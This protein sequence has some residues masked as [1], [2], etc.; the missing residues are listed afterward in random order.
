MIANRSP[1]TPT[2]MG[3]IRLRTAAVATAASMAL[4]PFFRMSNP[5]WAA[6]GWLVVTMPLRAMT[7][8][9]PC[10]SHPSARSPST[11]LHQAGFAVALHDWTGDCAIVS[12]ELA[13]IATN[14]RRETEFI[15]MLRS[16][17]SVTRD[18]DRVYSG[19]PAGD[20]TFVSDERLARP[21]EELK[22]RLCHGTTRNA[23]SVRS[24]PL[25]TSMT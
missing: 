11:A 24:V 9:R 13:M 3:S 19:L 12:D 22:M 16:L 10:G 5:A 1:P 14:T 4:P 7:S 15:V 8:E 6:S 23:S 17:P 21:G 2:F 25:A 20:S 18:Y